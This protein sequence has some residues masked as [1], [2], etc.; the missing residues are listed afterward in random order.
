MCETV[1][2]GPGNWEFHLLQ[3]NYSKNLESK[4]KRI[5]KCY[6]WIH[7]SDHIIHGKS[8]NINSHINC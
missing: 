3:K 5:E 2:N 6:L 7:D 1:Y 4:T 8:L